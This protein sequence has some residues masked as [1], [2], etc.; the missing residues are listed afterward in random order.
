MR[1]EDTL[2]TQDKEENPI[3]G[4]P[5]LSPVMSSLCCKGNRRT[6]LWQQ[7]GCHQESILGARQYPLCGGKNSNACSSGA[8]FSR[9]RERAAREGEAG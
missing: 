5:H 3:S 4:T 9:L 6:G 8:V 7:W 2:H 1:S